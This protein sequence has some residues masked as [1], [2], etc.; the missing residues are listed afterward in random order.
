MLKTR[1][2]SLALF[3]LLVVYSLTSCNFVPPPG[4]SILS[5]STSPTTILVGQDFS[6][7]IE[8]K[9]VSDTKA[10][11]LIPIPYENFYPRDSVSIKEDFRP[12][13]S[14]RPIKPIK[15]YPG[16]TY[17][18]DAKTFVKFHAQKV[19]TVMVTVKVQ[20]FYPDIEVQWFYYP[21]IVTI[22]PLEAKRTFSFT[23][24]PE[25]TATEQ[26]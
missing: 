11:Y 19:G 20:W 26:Y 2:V 22:V 14:A 10:I 4:A 12:L 16:D 9:N 25:K 18:I 5:F 8:V 13:I 1:L 21:D 15:L 23:I 3:L 6:Y 24:Y 17:K 7:S